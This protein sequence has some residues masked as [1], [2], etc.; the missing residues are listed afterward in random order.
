[1][2]LRSILIFASTITLVLSTTALI[3]QDTIGNFSK[4]NEYYAKGQYSQAI[5]QYL[6]VATSGK[7]SADLHYNLGN[8]YYKND[9]LALAIL[10]YEKAIKINSSHEDARF[11]LRLAQSKTVDKINPLPELF[12]VRWWHRW[13]Q[14]F[15]FDGWAQLSIAALILAFVGIALYIKASSEAGRIAFFS[16]S[17]LAVIFFLLSFGSSWSG[18]EKYK[19]DN[20]AIVVSPSTYVKSS[21]S[22]QGLD[23]FIL[24]EGAKGKVTDQIGTWW[25]IRMADGN[26][27]WVQKETIEVI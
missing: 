19:N 4:G 20:Y 13:V 26:E 22:T 23:L 6:K 1:M 27:G 25:R 16:L 15:S 3:G 7:T 11:N 12:Y 8:G 24:H 9:Q 14:L 18:Y 5:E 21:P 10:H 17:I 2:M